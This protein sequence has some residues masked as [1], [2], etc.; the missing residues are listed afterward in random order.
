MTKGNYYIRA[1]PDGRTVW[2]QNADGE[3][4]YFP[5]VEFEA[6]IGRM[7]GALERG[8]MPEVAAKIHDFFIKHF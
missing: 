6:F 5:R 4:G 3:G 8:I 7:V 1:E 2:I